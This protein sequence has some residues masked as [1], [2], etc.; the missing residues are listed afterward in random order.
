VRLAIFVVPAAGFVFHVTVDSDQE[1][2]L[3][4]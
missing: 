4:A 2:S 1:L 3:T